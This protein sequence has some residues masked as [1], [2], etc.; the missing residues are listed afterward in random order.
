M[1]LWSIV[2]KILL[3][4]FVTGDPLKMKRIFALLL[5]TV[6]FTFALTG[7][8]NE[9]KVD[10]T[11]VVTAA[12]DTKPSTVAPTTAKE[13]TTALLKNLLEGWDCCT[14]TCVVSDLH[15]LVEWNVEVNAYNRLLAGE[16]VSVNKLLHNC[17]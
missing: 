12:A 15:L 13:T 17:I 8:K 9:E 6:I 1:I 14:D 5:V 2:D 11:V 3:Y 7:C 4:F 16:I 10:E